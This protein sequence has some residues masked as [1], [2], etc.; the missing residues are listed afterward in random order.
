MLEVASQ[1]TSYYSYYLALLAS[2]AVSM[3]PSSI[4]D[5][6]RFRYSTG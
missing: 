4:D 3:S 6:A 5:S 1:V 2:Y